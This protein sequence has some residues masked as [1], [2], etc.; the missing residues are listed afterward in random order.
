MSKL[1][2]PLCEEIKPVDGVNKYMITAKIAN[3]NDFCTLMIDAEEATPHK[4]LALLRRLET[5]CAATV[6]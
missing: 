4:R 2:Y 5:E 1:F 6:S 3:S